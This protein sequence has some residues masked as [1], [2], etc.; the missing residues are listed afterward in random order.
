[1][2]ITQQL[3]V[4]LTEIC[5][6]GKVDQIKEQLVQRALQLRHRSIVVIAEMDTVTQMELGISIPEFLLLKSTTKTGSE[7]NFN[8]LDI[9]NSQCIS[10]SGV[11]KMLNSLEQKGYLVRERD[12]NIRRKIVVTLT[13]TGRKVIEY[14]DS[15]LDDYLTEYINAAGKD[16][17]EQFFVNVDHLFQVN[18][19]VK[20]KMRYK[21]FK[22]NQNIGE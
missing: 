21:Y 11:S 2:F 15:V 20:E 7:N 4:V 5:G 13:P 19:S 1:M 16:Y 22:T 6:G 10:K 18:E 8:F 3:D 14:F 9:Q 17:L 12:K